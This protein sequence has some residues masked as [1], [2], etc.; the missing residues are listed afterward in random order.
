MGVSENVGSKATGIATRHAKEEAEGSTEEIDGEELPVTFDGQNKLLNEEEVGVSENIERQETV[1]RMRRAKD[2]LTLGDSAG[3]TEEINGEEGPVLFD[4][5]SVYLNR[6]EV[7]VS[8]NVGGSDAI[9]REP[10]AIA[11]I[12]TAAEGTYS[13]LKLWTHNALHHA[14]EFFT[15]GKKADESED[16]ITHNKTN[17]T[18]NKNICAKLLLNEDL[19]SEGEDQKRHGTLRIVC[20]SIECRDSLEFSYPDSKSVIRVIP[21]ANG[22]RYKPLFTDFKY[23]NQL[24]D[25]QKRSIIPRKRKKSRYGRVVRPDAKRWKKINKTDHSSIPSSVTI[26]LDDKGTVSSISTDADKKRNI[27]RSLAR[28]KQQVILLKKRKR[29]SA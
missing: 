9:A 27:N 2:I 15:R 5:K 25:K 24:P 26:D 20:G 14:T 28:S 13:A 23:L 11:A 7:G 6:D 16:L 18:V 4:E 21:N 22:E 1:K 3:S 19:L 8:E 10:A 17:D 29:Q 12:A